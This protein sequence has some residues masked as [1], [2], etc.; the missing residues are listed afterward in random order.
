MYVVHVC[1]CDFVH[2]Y[3]TLVDW[4]VIQGFF[5]DSDEEECVC[6]GGARCIASGD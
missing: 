1:V 3:C 2:G 6:K 5:Q 4:Y